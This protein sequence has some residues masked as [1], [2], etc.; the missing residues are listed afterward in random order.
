M[1]RDVPEYSGMFRVPD[2]IG[3][4]K[5]ITLLY[6]KSYNPAI[7]VVHFCKIIVG[8]KMLANH[9][10]WRLMLFYTHFLLLLQPS[11]R[12]LSIITFNND[13]N[14][15]AKWILREFDVSRIRPRLD[16]LPHLETFAWQIWPRLRG[17]LSQFIVSSLPSMGE[18][19]VPSLK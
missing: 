6:M 1:F 17:L 12:W 10:F 8:K 19:L 15:P 11:V 13:A 7:P 3:A 14:P 18:S 9:M 2:F 5:K 16:R 4:S